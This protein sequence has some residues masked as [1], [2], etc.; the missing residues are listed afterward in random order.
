LI[1]QELEFFVF[2]QYTLNGL[3]R[4]QKRFYPQVRHYS[5]FSEVKGLGEEPL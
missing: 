3:R 1:L 2:E 5:P 4:K